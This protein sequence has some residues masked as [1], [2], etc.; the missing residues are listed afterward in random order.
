M[1]KI[2]FAV[3]GCGHIGKRHI[4]MINRNSEAELVA[5][6]DI[7]PKEL[8]DF[9]D[10]NK[11]TY[12]PSIDDML[13]SELEFDVVNIATPNGFHA[14]HSLKALNAGCHVVIEKPM[15]LTKNDA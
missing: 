14:E 11:A 4:E 12:F 6:V 1:T 7:K 8:I 5:Y 2:K 9:S 10:L 13:S 15:A 3:V